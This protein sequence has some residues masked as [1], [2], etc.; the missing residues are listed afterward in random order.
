MKKFIIYKF[1][2]SKELLLVVFIAFVIRMGFFIS[3]QPWNNEVVEKTVITSIDSDASLYHER[4]LSLLSKKSFDDFDTY[5][6]PGYP[7]FIALIYSISSG[8]VWFVLFIQILLNLISVVLVYKIAATIIHHK[9][10][11]LSAFLFAIDLHQSY[12]AVT[13]YTDTLF[14]FLFL[15][16]VYYLC[17]SIKE[18][19]FL[20][21]CLSALF[22]GI[23]T[24]VRP[25]SFLFPFVAVIFILVF[26]NFKLKMKLAYSLLFSIIFIATISPWLLHNYL[27]YQEAKLSAHSGYNL[28]FYDVAYTEVNRT[29]KTIEQVRKDFRDLA[30]KQGIDT[31]DA[32][33]FKNSKIFFNIAEQYIKNN[34]LLYCKRSLN[35]IVNMY[36]NLETHH[37]ASIFHLKSKSPID[38]YGEPSI[39]SIILKYFK[40]KSKAEIFIGFCMG[41]YLLINYFFALYGMFLMIGK[42]EKLVFLFILIILYFSALT[43][44]VGVA[45]YKMPFMPFI[46]IL[47][48]LGLFH[49]Y[50]KK[51]DKLGMNKNK[52]TTTYLFQ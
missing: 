4:A 12:W 23:A 45:R 32:N 27:K 26:C 22:L 2:D 16:S 7:V 52:T 41:L 20:S 1:F 38:L 8:S 34:F 35:G 11:L 10:A 39:F 44:V 30:I 24:L 5:R 43:G 36:A 50:E 13:L 48:A 18:N 51:I 49:F 33:S 42:K 47:C 29:G 6:T 14:V 46:N 31:T 25:I 19:N 21:I 15:V 40:T 28:L 9:I 3:L 17:K 37:I